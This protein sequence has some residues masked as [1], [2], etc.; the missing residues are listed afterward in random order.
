[1]KASNI[2]K[3]KEKKQQVPAPTDVWLYGRPLVIVPPADKKIGWH[4][5][6]LFVVQ[7]FLSGSTLSN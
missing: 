7:E 3:I 5:Y 4:P 1:M 2:L 6:S